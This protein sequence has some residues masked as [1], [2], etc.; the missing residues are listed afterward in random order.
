MYSLSKGR[1]STS[2]GRR[3]GNGNGNGNGRGGGYAEPEWAKYYG[4]GYVNGHGYTRGGDKDR[5][6]DK[7]EVFTG[8]TY[9]AETKAERSR[10]RVVIEAQGAPYGDGNR[11]SSADNKKS[12]TGILKTVEVDVESGPGSPRTLE[13]R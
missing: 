4:S 10:T 1:M 11:T 2:R 8:L 3:D 12:K 9:A 13:S 7:D 6:R 5:E